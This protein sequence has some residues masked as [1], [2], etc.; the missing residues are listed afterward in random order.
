[1]RPGHGGRRGSAT[2]LSRRYTRRV[3]YT[4]RPA[5]ESDLLEIQRIY[6]RA[7]QSGVATWDEEP[8]SMGKR[9]TWWLD[10][11]RDDPWSPVLVA[12]D[13][14]GGLAGFAY[15]SRM[16]QKSGWRFTREDTIYIDAAHQGKGLGRT[17]LTALLDEARRLGPRLI[18]ASIESENVA[19]IN[20]HR[21]L[22]FEDVGTMENA[23]FKFGRWLSCTYLQLDLG[24]R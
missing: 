12:D 11:H 15:L 10:E 7:I 9:V 24:E 22:G 17:L 8:W 23:G 14:E 16:S 21:S 3:G 6:N 2:D 18:I 1:M 4:I 19:S 20:L 5:I 13:G